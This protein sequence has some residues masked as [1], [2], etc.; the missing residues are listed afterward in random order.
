M[1]GQ[2][3]HEVRANINA[4]DVMAPRALTV[5]MADAAIAAMAQ[6]AAQSVERGAVHFALD[7]TSKFV[8]AEAAAVFSSPLMALLAT[9]SVLAGD[10]DVLVARHQA[11]TIF[12]VGLTDAIATCGARWSEV[13]AVDR[14]LE[15]EVLRKLESPESAIWMHLAGL[16]FS[17]LGETHFV[18][19]EVLCAL[20]RQCGKPSLAVCEIATFPGAEALP[21]TWPAVTELVSRYDLVI[22][23]GD[24][25][26]GGPGCGILVGRRDW[27]ERVAAHPLARASQAN[28]AQL[29][30]LGQTVAL[31]RKP[32]TAIGVP[33]LQMTAAKPENLRERAARIVSQIERRPGFADV[34]ILEQRCL[35]TEGRP[36]S[37]PGCCVA[38]TVR[39][40]SLE[41]VVSQLRSGPTAVWCTADPAENRLRL[42]LRG[43]LPRQDEALVSALLSVS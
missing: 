3:Q 11:G 34:A 9:V 8:G 12:D 26:L 13:G 40:N 19:E 38:I 17:I 10:G 35:L 21:S 30:G 2:P 16:G 15:A 22:S 18:S 27:I 32:E 20:A 41:D 4:T 28:C 1:L 7:A 42:N 36:E 43:V 6:A 31:L 29:A 23:P 37:L 14:L 33:L 25:F 39:N 5:P 24:R